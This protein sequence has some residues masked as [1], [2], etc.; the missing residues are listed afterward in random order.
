[1]PLR[2]LRNRNWIAWLLMTLFTWCDLLCMRCWVVCDVAHEWVLY[3]FCAIPMCDSMCDSN[4]RF[5]VST[6]QITSKPIASCEQFHKNACTEPL[7][8]AQQIAQCERTFTANLSLFCRRK[9]RDKKWRISLQ[10]YDSF[11]TEKQKIGRKKQKGNL[12][13]VNSETGSERPRNI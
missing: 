5:Y 12:S 11:C 9:F 3:L 10:I 4:V 6:L 13:I 1:M 8:H 2:F 7:S